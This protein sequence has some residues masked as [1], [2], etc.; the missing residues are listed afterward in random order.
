MDLLAHYGS[1]SEAEDGGAPGPSER[2]TNPSRSNVIAQSKGTV[3]GQAKQRLRHK[4]IMAKF[5][6]PIDYGDDLV[7]DDEGGTY[8][9]EE[10]RLMKKKRLAA[11]TGGPNATSLVKLLPPPQMAL[12]ASVK[13]SRM[14]VDSDD[15]AD[16]IPGLEDRT[17]MTFGQGEGSYGPLGEEHELQHDFPHQHDGVSYSTVTER[18]QDTNGINFKEISG[19]DLRYMDPG[20]RA[21]ADG[22]RSALGAD[23]ESRLRADAAKMG[24]VSKMARRRHQL[25]SLYVQAKEQELEQL[26][27]RATGMKTKAETQRKYGW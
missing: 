20:A 6:C 18:T 19:A 5:T 4:R 8:S 24:S 23:Y 14:K 26:E 9:D 11:H 1:D 27:K 10:S 7:G 25:S 2:A 12:P 21:E 13:E 17:G 16:Y 22:I 15:D 3:Q